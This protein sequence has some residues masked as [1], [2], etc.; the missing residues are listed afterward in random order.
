VGNKSGDKELGAFVKIKKAT[1]RTGIIIVAAAC[2]LLLFARFHQERI[3]E[4]KIVKVSGNIEGTEVRISFRVPGQIIE[5]LSDEGIFLKIGDMVARLNTDE[6]MKIKMEAE[7]ALN[8][9]EYKYKL[10]RDNHVRAENLFIAGAISDVDR[11]TAETKAKSTKADMETLRASLEL[12]KTRLGFAY[13]ASPLNGFVLVKSAET[14]EVIQPGAPV[15][16]ALD[17]DNIWVTGYINERDLGKVKLDQAAHV[18]TDTY[19][20]KKYK[21]W[22]SFISQEAEF[23]PKYIQTDIERVKLVYRIKVR[24][25]NSSLDLKPGMPADAYITVK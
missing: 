14:G 8:A 22:V 19:P 24:V 7:A 20:G 17:L 3:V 5:L 16:T 25:N 23:T 21:G 12:A 18:Q 10:A 15:F 2:L 6:L 4:E 11:E 13:L 1:I 9:A